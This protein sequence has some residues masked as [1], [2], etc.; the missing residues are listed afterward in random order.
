[1]IAVGLVCV[2]LGLITLPL[3]IP[4]GLVLMVVGLALLILASRY[5]RKLVR[6]WRE[7]HPESS[8]KLDYV[9]HKLPRWIRVPLMR[10]RPIKR[11]RAHIRRKKFQAQKD[12]T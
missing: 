11:Y 4:V 3:P 6:Q 7:S 2:V 10:T 8:D 9:S 12:E 5:V 1:M